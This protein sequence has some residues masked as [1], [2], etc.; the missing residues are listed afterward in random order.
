MNGVRFE[1]A[2]VTTAL[3]SP[4]RAYILAGLCARTHRVVDRQGGMSDSPRF[5][6]R[7]L[8]DAD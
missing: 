4:S 2:F 3:Y 8:Q 5:F 7:D 6:S 1:K